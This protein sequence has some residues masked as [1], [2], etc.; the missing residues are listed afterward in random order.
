MIR[1]SGS[2]SMILG[3][4]ADLAIARSSRE[5]KSWPDMW[6]TAIADSFGVSNG[7]YPGIKLRPSDD[8]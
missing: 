3:A 4:L 8:D 1:C 2:T 5:A 6:P 7:N